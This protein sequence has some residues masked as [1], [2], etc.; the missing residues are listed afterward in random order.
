MTHATRDSK[1]IIVCTFPSHHGL[2]DWGL[3]V[4]G[5]FLKKMWQRTKIATRVDSFDSSGWLAPLTGTIKLLLYNDN[6]NLYSNH[7]ED[8]HCGMHINSMLFDIISDDVIFGEVGLW[9][10]R[11]AQIVALNEKDKNSIFEFSEDI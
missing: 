11:G 4:R 9:C 8:E 2:S 3:F 6:A 5:V 10:K 7:H 1:C